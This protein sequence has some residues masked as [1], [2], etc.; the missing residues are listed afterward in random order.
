MFNELRFKF[1]RFMQGRYGMDQ[2]S[3]FLS[4]LLLVL[5]AANFFLRIRA[6]GLL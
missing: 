2:F 6:I 5:V 1:A 4:G 3:R